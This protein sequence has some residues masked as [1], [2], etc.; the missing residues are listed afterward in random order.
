MA[1]RSRH[2]RHVKVGQRIDVAVDAK[3]LEPE[4]YFSILQSR[5]QQSCRF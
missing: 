1:P 4:K 3:E 5:G 2:L